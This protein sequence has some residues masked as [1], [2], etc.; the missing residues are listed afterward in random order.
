MGL[1]PGPAKLRRI[2]N[3]AFV[4]TSVIVMMDVSSHW[5]LPV[6]AVGPYKFANSVLL[7]PMAGITDLPFRRLAWRLGAGMV[8]GE[9]TVARPDLWNT[10]KS[11]E[12]RRL[13]SCIQPAA[14]Q[15]AGAEPKWLAD[16]ADGTSKTVLRSSTSTWVVRRR[17]CA[18]KRQGQRY[19][20]TNPLC[21]R[22][23]RR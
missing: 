4:N 16:I 22:S 18:T 9:M 2:D 8:Y 15:I 12:R 20:V 14:V 3:V 10:R 21:D 13:D 23:L 11:I 7:A 19:Y 1:A 5:F 17:R 6:V